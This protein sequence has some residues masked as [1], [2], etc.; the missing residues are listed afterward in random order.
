MNSRKSGWCSVK[1]VW[2]GVTC[3]TVLTMIYLGISELTFTIH[4][5]GAISRTNET[6]LDMGTKTKT[7]TTLIF[8]TN[9]FR[10]KV[11]GRFRLINAPSLGVATAL[12]TT[13]P[14]YWSHGCNFIRHII[15]G[16]AFRV[17]IFQ[18][19]TN[20]TVTVC[21]PIRY[22]WIIFQ[23]APESQYDVFRFAKECDALHLSC[24]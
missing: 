16:S 20:K 9:W 5:Y 24:K 18:R 15:H 17:Q 3:K 21:S 14:R 11:G 10:R 1:Q 19:K 13:D 22:S 6:P 23:S 2:L 12:I 8:N 7:T 4:D